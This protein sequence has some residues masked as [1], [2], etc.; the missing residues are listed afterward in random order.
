MP[1]PLLS[2][3]EFLF[4]PA[5]FLEPSARLF[6]ETPHML[7]RAKL[8]FVNGALSRELLKHPACVLL[9]HAPVGRCKRNALLGMRWLNAVLP[10][11]LVALASPRPPACKHRLPDFFACFKM[12]LVFFSHQAVPLCKLEALVLVLRVFAVRPARFTAASAG[13]AVARSTNEL[14]CALCF[15]LGH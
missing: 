10:A 13:T 12:L 7:G 4:K 3:A 9:R 11:L 14:Q 8:P 2:S 5:K 1:L 6:F 15:R